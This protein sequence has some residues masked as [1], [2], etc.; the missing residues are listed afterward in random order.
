MSQ[1]LKKPFLH[2][3]FLVTVILDLAI[4]TAANQ[5]TK[6][7]VQILLGLSSYGP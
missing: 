4:L 5:Q 3:N 1:I 6:F 2:E 7:L